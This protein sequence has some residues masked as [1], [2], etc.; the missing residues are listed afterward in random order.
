M[1]RVLKI[2]NA[3]LKKF[4]FEKKRKKI[5]KEIVSYFLI[6]CEGEKTEPNYF[7]S[8]PKKIGKVVY[9]ITMEEEL[10]HLK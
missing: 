1:A 6:V 5:K 4:S 9:D 2:D 10:V 8:F 3:I 7:K